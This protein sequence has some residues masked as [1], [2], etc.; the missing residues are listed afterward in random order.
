MYLI[1]QKAF[2]I[3]STGA[4]HLPTSPNANEA[5]HLLRYPKIKTPLSGVFN[6]G[7]YTHRA[8]TIMP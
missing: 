6:I 5:V 3:P 8:S 7:S 4:R 1:I 2:Q